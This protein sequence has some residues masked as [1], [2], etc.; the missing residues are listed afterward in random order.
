MQANVAKQADI[1]RLFSE[2]KKAF[3]PLDILVNNAGIYEFAPIESITPEHFH[4][5]FDLNVLG[6]ILA[7]QEAAKHFGPE[8]G[9]IINISSVVAT[10]RPARHIGLQRDQGRRRRHDPV[11]RQGARPAEDPRQLDQPRHGR[12]RRRARPPG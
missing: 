1:Q 5:M 4:K 9:S 3:G 7:S 11:A 8:G 12:D 10:L 6:L 2:T